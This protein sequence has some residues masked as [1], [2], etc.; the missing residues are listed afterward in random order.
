MGMRVG[1]SAVSAIA[2]LRAFAVAVTSFLLLLCFAC[3]FVSATV[4]SSVHHC[5]VVKSRQFEP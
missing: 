3:H 1:E 2:D 4:I 5:E